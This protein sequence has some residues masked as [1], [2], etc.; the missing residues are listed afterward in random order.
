MGKGENIGVGIREVEVRS[1]S[2]LSPGSTERDLLARF[3]SEGSIQPH[4][5][6]QLEREAYL[7][8]LFR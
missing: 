7:N 4:T 8:N 6:V 2:G 3:V 5:G 1:G